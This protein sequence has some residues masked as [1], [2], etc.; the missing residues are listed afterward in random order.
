MQGE[1]TPWFWVGFVESTHLIG[2]LLGF[3]QNFLV[4]GF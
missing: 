1:K 4:F 3:F 2:L